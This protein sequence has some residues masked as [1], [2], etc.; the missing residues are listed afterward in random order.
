MLLCMV[1]HR[2][3]EAGLREVSC[4]S[5]FQKYTPVS[6][7]GHWTWHRAEANYLPTS[8]DCT[9]S[10][11]MR[12]NTWVAY[13]YVYQC[14]DTCEQYSSAENQLAPNVCIIYLSPVNYIRTFCKGLLTGDHHLCNGCTISGH[15][16]GLLNFQH[17]VLSHRLS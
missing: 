17:R 2:E 4:W 8:T 12:D 6:R 1:Y 16:I 5:H 9:Q 10:F 3:R 14:Y 13:W 15:L 7:T 11:A